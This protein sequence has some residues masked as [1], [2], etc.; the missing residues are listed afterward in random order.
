MTR[1]RP[2][3]LKTQQLPRI[4]DAEWVVMQTIWQHGPLTTNQVVDNLAGQ[5]DWKPKTI[6]TLLKRL[7][8]KGALAFEK[9]GR[10]YRFH[11]QI[12]ADEAEHTVARTFLDRFFGGELAPFLA[13]FVEREKLSAAELVRLKNILDHKQS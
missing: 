5:S 10:E 12:S 7:V 8:D 4:S 1:K 6:H 13:R 2:T 9:A 3:P 11:P